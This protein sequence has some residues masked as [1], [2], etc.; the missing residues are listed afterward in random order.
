VAAWQVIAHELW[1]SRADPASRL[2]DPGVKAFAA[3]M[4]PDQSAA[5]I[6]VV[7]A[8]A[9][10]LTHVEVVDAGRPGTD[11]VVDRLIGLV[12]QHKPCAVV[13]DAAGTAGR[14]IAPL[15]AAR[16]EVIKPSPRDAAAAC[17][18]FFDAVTQDTLRHLDQPAL[19]SALSGAQRRPLGDAWAWARKTSSVNIAPLVAVTLAAWGYAT[20]AHLATQAPSPFALFGK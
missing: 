17:G 2:P 11:W 6:G 12:R 5:A 8:R 14:W 1:A 4:T 3:D 10:G 7:G 18:Q 19:A 9:D 15:E 16:V 20:R 13:I